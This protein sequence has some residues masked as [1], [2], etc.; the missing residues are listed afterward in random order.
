[1]AQAFDTVKQ[2]I[3]L[4]PN[5]FNELVQ[6]KEIKKAFK[7]NPQIIGDA[8]TLINYLEN[9]GFDRLKE[10]GDFIDKEVR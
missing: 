7:N 10:A 4:N 2:Q 6:A 5:M 9:V 8:E 3:T 1:L